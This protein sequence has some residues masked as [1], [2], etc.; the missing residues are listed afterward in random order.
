VSTETRPTTADALLDEPGTFIAGESITLAHAYDLAVLRADVRG[1]R[2]QV[3]P[4]YTA[5]FYV[6]DVLTPPDRLKE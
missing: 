6:L 2:Q 1:V 4:G 3:K 5:G